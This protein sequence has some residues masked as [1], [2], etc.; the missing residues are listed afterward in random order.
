MR[1]ID[2]DVGNWCDFRRNFPPIGESFVNIEDNRMAGLQIALLGG[3][4]IAGDEKAARA[5]LTRKAKAL[6]AYLALRGAR[7]QSREKLAELLWGNSPEAQ[8]RTNLRQTLSSIRKALSGAG[9]PYLVTDGDQISLAGSGVDLD[10]DLFENLVAETAP[11]AL[12]RAAVLYKGDLLDGFSLKESSF[13]AW[14]RP[15]RERLRGLAT[16]ALSR[17]IV[18][19]EQARDT[20]AAI[21]AA[22]RLLALDSLQEGAH[23]GLMW[24]Y[25]A[26]GR[27]ASALK[28]FEACRD[29]LRRELGVEPETDTVALYRDIRQQRAAAPTR[30]GSGDTGI[31]IELSLPENPSIAVLPFINM[32]GDPEQ[33][34]FSDGITED[35]ITELSKFRW[36][37]VISRN[38][39]FVYKGQ[40]VDVKQVGR[41]L[42]VRYVLEG[43]VRKAANRVR[44]SA[45]LIE[46]ETGS[47]VWA[48]R[49]DRS[50]EDIF[51]LQD[52]VTSAIAAA[53]EPELAGSERQRAMHKP[54][55]HLG[56]WDLFQRGVALMWR[57]DHTS[58][59]TGSELIRQAVELDPS[60]GRAHGH[61]AFG[62]LLL[63]VYEWADDRDEVL[64]QGIA[65]AGKGIAADQRDYFA[66]H[67]LGRLKTIAGDHAAAVRALETCMSINP[68][69]ALGYVGLGEAHVYS[70]DPEKAI[71]YTDSAIRL[72][73]NDPMMWGMLHYK[74]SA[75]VRLDDFDRAIELFERV[76]EY[77]TVQYVPSTTLAALYVIRGREAEG[78]KA[79]RNARRLEPKLSIA[80]MK[81]VYG[82][83]GDQPGARTQRLLDAL[84]TA[85]LAEE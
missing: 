66:Y 9:S 40:A 50:L 30:Q 37:F 31:G 28:Q 64:R 69:F 24:A 56:A 76:C 11:D 38:S 81:N 33:V 71:A 34:F 7:G 70:G 78:R 18:H 10:V 44:I 61:L 23:R 80:V 12:E 42:G 6:V 79:L 19:Y 2:P 4:E 5:S 83:S 74:A 65:D 49:Y 22:T 26:Q 25:S 41:E 14:V 85:G 16:A 29:I 52:E 39:T 54:T 27:Q 59:N 48:E 53:V 68:N 73:P 3:L 20:E 36:F 57:H 58:V 84:R 15:E 60:F 46:A 72:S 35:I 21:Q 82:V 62:A 43:S 51:E 63:L 8:A 45:Q 47:H 17:L 77:P 75:Y 32:S 1:K 67:A 55:E 13:E